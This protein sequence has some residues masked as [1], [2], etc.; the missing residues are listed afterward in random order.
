[1]PNDQINWVDE[2]ERAGA[3]WRWPGHGP[4]PAY[5]LSSHHADFYLNTDVIANDGRLLD[6]VIT[7]GLA[8]RVTTPPDFVASPALSIRAAEVVGRA[9]ANHLGVPFARFDP[10]TQTWAGAPVA[11]RRAVVCTDDI[12]GG[13]SAR[14]TIRAVRT[15]E[16][17]VECVLTLAN[18]CGHSHL[19]GVP[20]KSLIEHAFGVWT[21]ADCPLCRAGSPAIDPRG[22][23]T[24]L[25]R[26][27]APKK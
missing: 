18:F 17:E 13:G 5:L 14:Q 7:R 10:S 20:I 21:P 27:A 16:A 11:P 8:A 3:V 6:R 19:D 12:H 15:L 1:M 22:R 4:H 23:W 24:D 25:T 2:F 26:G 9:L